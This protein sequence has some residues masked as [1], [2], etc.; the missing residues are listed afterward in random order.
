MFAGFSLEFLLF[1]RKTQVTLRDLAAE[2]DDGY[3]IVLG[4]LKAI[5]DEGDVEQMRSAFPC[6]HQL[7]EPAI[8]CKVPAHALSLLSDCC[9]FYARQ[10]AD[11]G[12]SQ[13]A[14][15]T[16]GMIMEY[17]LV[18][19]KDL[20][21]QFASTPEED[22]SSSDG[23]EKVEMV[24]V[25]LLDTVA[26]LAT[27]KRCEV[28]KAALPSLFGA[29]I[30][31]IEHFG[32]TA[33]LETCKGVLIP[34]M[35]RLQVCLTQAIT[36]SDGPVPAADKKKA[37][38]SDSHSPV[39]EEWRTSL[40]EAFRGTS[41]AL[42]S[43]YGLKLAETPAGEPVFAAFMGAYEEC[44]SGGGDKIALAVM[45]AMRDIVTE[46]LS[47]ATLPASLWQTLW[48]STDRAVGM[49]CVNKMIS[50]QALWD[51]V[52]YLST[53]MPTA[54]KAGLL[55]SS[56][57]VSL[58]RLV[59][60]LVTAGTIDPNAVSPSKFQTAAI[61]ELKSISASFGA[62]SP[63]DQAVLWHE[64]FSVLLAH[65]PGETSLFDW[66]QELPAQER[67]LRLN[68]VS[69]ISAAIAE[70]FA[71]NTPP[72]VQA[73]EV[74]HVAG[75][76]LCTMCSPHFVGDRQ[77]GWAPVADAMVSV[78]KCGLPQLGV[79]GDAEMHVRAWN[80]VTM[81][82]ETFFLGKHRSAAGGALPPQALAD[83]GAGEAPAVRL[84]QAVMADVL[85][86]TPNMAVAGDLMLIVDSHIVRGCSHSTAGIEEEEAPARTNPRMAQVAL[87]GVFA[88]AADR[89]TGQG[90]EGVQKIASR[91][92]VE[93]ST[94]V[95]EKWSENETFISLS[96][97]VG[98]ARLEQLTLLC[99]LLC[100][101]D[102]SLKQLDFVFDV[103]LGT[104]DAGDLLDAPDPYPWT[105]KNPSE[106]GKGFLLLMYPA[107]CDCVLSDTP[108]VRE[109]LREV[110]LATQSVMPFRGKVKKD[111]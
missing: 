2:L 49:A 87:E 96:T 30:R 19:K 98:K 100:K 37:R 48:T 82:L 36:E 71:K 94:F 13:Q 104:S 106:W 9:V 107:I 69:V 108:E 85:P 7:C 18:S 73:S 17:V 47:D 58:M 111:S 66:S 70:S 35:G 64:F 101:L 29:L 105:G 25:A 75:L 8:I 67:S 5:A 81:G 65:L 44:L 78:A 79:S 33:F 39:V 42:Y 77:D 72:A 76:L 53:T 57:V 55:N 22:G 40:G 41:Q 32:E 61:N 54:R 109:G 50:P 21:E 1:T 38:R 27:E 11:E 97:D 24:W 89:S 91:I 68:L 62:S 4:L 95:F 83:G 15:S 110:L 43:A 46:R 45:G 84:L 12:V 51:V 60:R 92:V 26:S 16:M 102:M 3:P 20:A 23:G 59:N 74:E 90:S 93:R 88:L 63:E 56:N 6:L 86:H 10:E 52:K 103:V 80:L 34:M 14:A 31:G 99:K 28:R